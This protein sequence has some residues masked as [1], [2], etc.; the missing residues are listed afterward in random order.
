MDSLKDYLSDIISS[1]EFDFM[2]FSQHYNGGDAISPVEVVQKLLKQ[3]EK[4]QQTMKE[5]KR[6]TE[7][8]HQ[9]T[10]LAVSQ[11]NDFVN[12]VLS[13]LNDNS[14]KNVSLPLSSQEIRSTLDRVAKYKKNFENLKFCYREL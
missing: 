10:D 3:N 11:C 6:Q 8:Y 9:E 13:I 5:N 4:L 7:A 12:Q 14:N 2:S 1:S